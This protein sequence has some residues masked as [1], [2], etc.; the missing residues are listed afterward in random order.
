MVNGYVATQQRGEAEIYFFIFM[1]SS[2]SLIVLLRFLYFVDINLNT[3]LLHCQCIKQKLNMNSK[4]QDLPL[5]L[6]AMEDLCR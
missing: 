5:I 4:E 6:R 2:H 1:Y 3:I